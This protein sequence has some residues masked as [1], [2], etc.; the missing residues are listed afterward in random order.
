[1]YDLRGRSKIKRETTHVIV[2]WT[3]VRDAASAH[4][5]EAHRHRDPQ[6]RA[7]VQALL[8]AKH[9]SHNFTLAAALH[10]LVGVHLLD[11]ATRTRLAPTAR[12]PE[13]TLTRR[14]G[15]VLQVELQDVVKP[16]TTEHASISTL[17]E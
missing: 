3:R 11:A 10:P 4:R 6:E 7:L 1:M 9:I 8:Q 17:N 13:G 16:S 5:V 14:R 2:R 15:H 12:L